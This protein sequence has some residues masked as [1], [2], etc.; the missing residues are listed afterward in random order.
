M[1]NLFTVMHTS[2]EEHLEIGGEYDVVVIGGGIAGVAAA[3]S[4]SRSGKSVLI[5]EKGV[6]LGG[7]ATM[8]L[9]T[10]YLPLCDGYG[11]KI[12]SG[13]AEELLY[14]SI[15]CGYDTL[16]EEWR[17]GP[18][19]VEKASSRYLTRF[20]PSEFVAVLD[21]M[22]QQE[23][24]DLIFD[25]VFTAPVM[26][27]GICRAVIVEE[28]GGRKVYLGKV[29]IDATG[30]CDLAYRAGGDTE[31]FD[32]WCSYWVYNTDLD[33]MQKALETGHIIDAFDVHQYGDSPMP[34]NDKGKK[35]I[36][37]DAKG[38]TEFV[39]R[40]RK[41]LLDDLRRM[42]KSNTH[43]TTTIPAMAQVRTTRRLI[44]AYT[45]TTDDLNTHFD[46]SVGAVSDWRFAGPLYEIP[47][48]CLYTPQLKNILA[49][50]RCISATGD[51]WEVTRVIP[52]AALTGQACG[53]AA[54]MMIEASAAA[55]QVNIKELQ[56]KLSAAGVLIHF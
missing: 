5:I 29:F 46:D 31:L 32:N 11:R 34:G 27:N 19:Y 22:M 38:V 33:M 54:A 3:L 26:E 50:G 42:G 56:E 40:G 25:T 16:P 4:A 53:T 49:S 47:Y 1:D 35:M 55:N 6:M 39:L 28:K 15:E 36:I 2:A 20:S 43:C 48:R 21:E 7:L 8:G 51:T 24:I 18:A 37:K 9:I 10:W 41:Y 14:K 30:D 52:P 13:I 45:L 44:G 17:G 23:H 12:I